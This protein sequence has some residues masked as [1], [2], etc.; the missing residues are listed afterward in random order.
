MYCQYSQF[1][2]K[3]KKTLCL[4][5]AL[6]WAVS[7][8]AQTGQE[9]VERMN[10]RF[11]ERKAD[12]ICLSVDVKIPILGTVTTKTYAYGNKRRMDVE[13]SDINTITFIDDTLQWT[14]IPGTSE[15]A[16]TNIKV[17]NTNT[18][19]E[20]GMDE[21]MFD[22]IPGNYDITIKSQNSVKWELQCKRKKAIK[23]DDL[24]KAVT[25]EVRKD[26]YEPISMSTKVMGINC[27]MH[28]FIFG[29][30][31]SKVTF[32]LDDYPGVTINDQRNKL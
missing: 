1:N 4:Y 26:T 28:H 11:S 32:N 3:M 5:F 16:L 24:P 25:L 6:V 8:F 13:T 7:A 31:E 15:V 29:I 2:Y 27:T 12:G 20:P 23:D 19:N 18:S 30:P 22:D 14:Y 21:G 9:I 17:G 10:Q